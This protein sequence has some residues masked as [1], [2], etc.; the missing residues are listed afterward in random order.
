VITAVD[1]LAYAVALGVTAAIP[2]LGITAVVARSIT[3]GSP[4]GY[5]MLFG[6]MVAS[7]A[8]AGAA[9]SMLIRDY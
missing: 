9:C 6:L 2:G 3:G 7:V 4:A 8:M 1:L 5:A